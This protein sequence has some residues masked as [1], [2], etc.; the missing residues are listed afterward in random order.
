[1]E[2]TGRFDWMDEY[3]Q[4]SQSDITC[5]VE[6]SFRRRY[7]ERNISLNQF[8]VTVITHST[9]LQVMDK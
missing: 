1:M 2:C 3:I 9:C 5:Q 8:Y 7:F 4:V 6:N